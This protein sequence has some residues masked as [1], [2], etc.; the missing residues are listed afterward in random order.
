MQRRQL[1]LAM[2]PVLVR[3]VVQAISDSQEGWWPVGRLA[4]ICCALWRPRLE[5][6]KCLT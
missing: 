6:R 2:L 1:S 3:A 5:E 4:H